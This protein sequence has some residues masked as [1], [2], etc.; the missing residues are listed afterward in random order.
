MQRKD[1]FEPKLLFPQYQEWL[2]DE[3][4]RQIDYANRTREALLQA[5][6]VLSHLKECKR[7][8]AQFY[9]PTK[10]REYC[11]ECRD[12][13]DI[14]AVAYYKYASINKYYLNKLGYIPEEKQEV[15]S[16]LLDIINNWRNSLMDSPKQNES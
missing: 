11:L 13:R 2:E 6:H 15:L 4:Q 12:A 9:A 1:D 3:A 16:F 8:S 5:E 7:C 14:Y 10:R